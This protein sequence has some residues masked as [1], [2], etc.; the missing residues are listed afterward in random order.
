[1]H[2]EFLWNELMTRDVEAACRFYGE[3]LGWVF[4]RRP[5]PDGTVYIVA[6][7]DGKAVAGIFDISAPMFAE[8]PAHWFSYI[9][10]DDVDS[11]FSKATDTGAKAIRPPF[12]VSGVG[13]IT[14][15]TDPT[16]AA[17]GLWTPAKK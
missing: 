14:I 13:R 1:M 12:D 11:I 15:I 17:I 4:E 3:L 10:V 2:G 6:K 8:L 7:L 16:E 5:N 9:A